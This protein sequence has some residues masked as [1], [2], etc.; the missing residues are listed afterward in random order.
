M[1]EG[2][3]LMATADKLTNVTSPGD[4]IILNK[5]DVKK[6][7]SNT[8]RALRRLR[9]H[10]MALVGLLM[11]GFILVW[12]VGGA[13]F[14]T[15][16]QS[17]FNDPSIVFQSP[18]AAHPMG[19]DEV[20][21]DVLARTIYG[22]QISLIIGVTAVLVQIL[23]GTVV[24]LVAGYNG[25][26]IDALL[27]RFVEAMLSIPQLFLALMAVRV[28]AN[29]LPDFTIGGRVFSNTLIVIIFV[30]GLTSWMHIAR[31]VRATVL[32]I[33]E[34]EFVTAARSIG[35]TNI[36]IILRHILPNCMAP[37]IVAATLGIAQAIL[38]EAYLGFL[39][40]GVRNP[41]ATWGNM[42]AN[43]NSS[44]A[45]PDQ[46]Y[47]WLFPSLFVIITVLGINLFGDGLRDA[48]DPKATK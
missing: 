20:G 42:L 12:T 41:T 48:L 47:M 4:I 5:E 25:G 43:A 34:Q 38:I 1:D 32:S 7:V 45:I 37:L 33:R 36:R 8:Q 11:L 40:L 35:A 44:V 10:R 39:G 26:F 19:T 14:Y 46:Y 27:M 24:G 29:R 2:N 30:I 6:G 9:Q 3:F 21:R 22:G 23:V 28:F 16:A 15:E 17:N 31:I 13:L 18:S